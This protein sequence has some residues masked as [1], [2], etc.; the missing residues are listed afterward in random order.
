MTL[1]L[2]LVHWAALNGP[3]EAALDALQRNV[4]QMS[5][6]LG[7]VAGSGERGASSQ[8]EQSL[9]GTLGLGQRSLYPTVSRAQSGQIWRAAS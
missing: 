4:T 2:M 9:N 1:R 6:D 7:L 5:K 8:V 3:P